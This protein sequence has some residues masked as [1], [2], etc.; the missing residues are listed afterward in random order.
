MNLN[1]HRKL[2]WQIS[3]RELQHSYPEAWAE[4]A[5][6]E[7]IQCKWRK[8]GKFSKIEA[9]GNVFKVFEKINHKLENIPR[10]Y[11]QMPCGTGFV[12][13]RNFTNFAIGFSLF[14]FFTFRCYS[15][16]IPFVC[17]PQIQSSR[18]YVYPYYLCL[19]ESALIIKY[20]DF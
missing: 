18:T 5:F 4:L 17:F 6:T 10:G 14:R 16:H 12:R 11:R 20:Q 2:F 7:K 1:I 13:Q 19:D 9:F 3:A 8:F 15:I